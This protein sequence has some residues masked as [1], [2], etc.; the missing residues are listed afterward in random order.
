MGLGLGLEQAVL[1]LSPAVPR[2]AEEAR[3]RGARREL[4]LRAWLGSGLGLGLGLGL[5]LE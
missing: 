3:R 4:V 2:A 5:R 1:L